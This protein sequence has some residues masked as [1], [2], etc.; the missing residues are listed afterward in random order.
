MQVTSSTTA[1][2]TASSSSSHTKQQMG[3][4]AT[5]G[6][7]HQQPSANTPLSRGNRAARTGLVEQPLII[8]Q[9]QQSLSK[10]IK[11]PQATH[12]IFVDGD[13]VN[14]NNGYSYVERRKPEAQRSHTLT[15]PPSRH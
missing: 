12:L 6:F 3:M 8:G 14:D 9:K 10:S 15:D 11:Q 2:A 4:H 1:G 7:E 5:G 13:N